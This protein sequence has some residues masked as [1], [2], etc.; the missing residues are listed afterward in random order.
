MTIRQ[1]SIV[2]WLLLV[3]FWRRAFW[4]LVVLVV[5]FVLLLFHVRKSLLSFFDASLLERPWAA[6]GALVYPWDMGLVVVIAQHMLPCSTQL[7]Q[8]ATA[9]VEI[10]AADALDDV[11][12]GVVFGL[13]WAIQRSA[14]GNTIRDGRKWSPRA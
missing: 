4:L 1:R 10:V 2:L 14:I 11:G 3:A 8:H 9:V 7:A 13:L 12:H 6:V 5:I